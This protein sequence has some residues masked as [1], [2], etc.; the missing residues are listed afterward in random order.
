M[1]IEI[2]QGNIVKQPDVDALVNSANAN[3][4]LGSGVAGAIHTAAGPKL[5][6]YCKPFA[7]LAYGAYIVTPGFK[8]PNL[9]VIHVRAASYENHKDAPALLR[10]AVGAALQGAHDNDIRR[11]AIPAIGT[12]VFAFPPMLAAQIMAETLT[13]AEALALHLELVRVCVT[14]E[15]LRD[16][17]TSAFEQAGLKAIA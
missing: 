4:R 3:L 13:R 11:I 16:V 5:E 10:S 7:P 8:L 1:K 12:G 17:Y 15:H 6:E 9:W 14:S 2:V